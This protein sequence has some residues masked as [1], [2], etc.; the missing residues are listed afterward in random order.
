MEETSGS[1]NMTYIGI[2]SLQCNFN[3]NKANLQDQRDSSG[4]KSTCS[5]KGPRLSSQT[6]VRW[7]LTTCNS[8][9]RGFGSL[10]WPPQAHACMHTCLHMGTHRLT[11]TQIF[12][13]KRTCSVPK[14]I[15]FFT[16]ERSKQFQLEVLERIPMMEAS[17]RPA[18]E[19]KLSQRR[20]NAA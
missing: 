18:Q 7:L 16:F 15:T 10:F 13:R 11:H 4:V 20:S 6:W 17:W 19:D 8:S 12:K 3:G 2:D 14:N 9:L 1:Q 5:S